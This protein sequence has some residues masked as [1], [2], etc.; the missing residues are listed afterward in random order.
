[1]QVFVQL[2]TLRV[3]FSGENPNPVSESKKGFFVFLG[4]YK[5][6]FESYESAFDRDSMDWI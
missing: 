4:K 6:G 2:E 5:K 3:H 1:M